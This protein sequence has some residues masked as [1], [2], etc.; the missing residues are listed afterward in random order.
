MPVTDSRQTVS[1]LPIAT[2]GIE[3][4][5]ESPNSSSRKR[6]LVVED[7]QHAAHLLEFMLKRAGYDVLLAK[8]GREAQAALQSP[9]PAD[10]IVLDLMLPYVSGYQILIDAGN[11]EAW[12]DVPVI[13]VTGRTLEMDAVRA[14]DMGAAD[15]VR[16]PFQPDELLARI[17][18]TLQATSADGVAA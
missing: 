5:G 2:L 4:V 6:V 18:R 3:S 16:K 13:V 17:R 10:L 1:V 14:L 11:S 7:N 8:D 15:F 12:R 9:E